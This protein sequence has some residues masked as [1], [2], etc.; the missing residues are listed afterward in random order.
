MERE[1]VMLE[2]LKPRLRSEFWIVLLD[3]IAVNGAYLLA[4][5][6]RFYVHFRFISGIGNFRE[7]YLQF[8]PYYTLACLFVFYICGLYGGMWRYA[9]ITDV[10]RIVLANAITSVIQVAGTKLFV[11]GMPTGYYIVG[12]FLQLLM[13]I[14]IR[15][16]A[17]FFRLGK[18]RRDKQKSW[19]IPCMV[20]GSGE[21]GIGFTRY[22]EENS[23]F[24]VVVLVGKNTGKMMDGI[25][26]VGAGSIPL[27][28]KTYGVH[29]VFIADEHLS[30]EERDEI[31][32]AVEAAG[33]VVVKDYLEYLADLPGCLP[34]NALIG[35]VDGPVT[36]VVD[37][38][39]KR[40]DNMQQCMTVLGEKFEVRKING[41]KVE[42]ERTE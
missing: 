19:S 18:R 42:L 15:F 36:V 11:H 41:A 23:P 30:T 5:L 21:Q 12:G 28:I 31:K 39:E 35:V 13:I 1:T 37:G 38:V 10:Y 34:L 7:Y 6:I 16:T 20:V 27:Q 26:I 32:K 24:E 3:I 22:L 29:T 33:D 4:I 2:K 40:Y 9:G 14:G 8:T 17:S 25:P